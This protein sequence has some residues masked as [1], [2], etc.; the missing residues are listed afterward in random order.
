M[1]GWK[2]SYPNMI[3]VDYTHPSATLSNVQCYKDARC[4][5]VM[6][7]TGGDPSKISEILASVTKQDDSSIAAVIAPNMGKQIVA[8]QATLQDMARRF[9]GAFDGYKLEVGYH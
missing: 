2:K 6:G 8:M 4:D 1:I 5:F 9:P 7:T 3:V